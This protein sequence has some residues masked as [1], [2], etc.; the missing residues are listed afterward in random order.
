MPS[1][2]HLRANRKWRE[3]NLQQITDK[4]REKYQTNEEYRQRIKAY[5]LAR[6]HAKKNAVIDK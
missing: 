4:A 6:Y 3:K 2:A 1:E 5:N